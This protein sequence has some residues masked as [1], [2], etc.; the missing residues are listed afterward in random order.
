MDRRERKRQKKPSGGGEAEPLALEAYESEFLSRGTVQ[1]IHK[2]LNIK[3]AYGID[4]RDFFNLMQSVAE[5]KEWMDPENKNLDEFVPTKIMR[6][7]ASDFVKGF[8]NLMF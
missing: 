6:Q 4:D 3:K 1:L 8:V 2:I 5:E 7:F